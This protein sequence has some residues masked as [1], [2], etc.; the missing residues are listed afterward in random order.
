MPDNKGDT[1][2]AEGLPGPVAAWADS[3]PA[4]GADFDADA[5][6]F[7][8]FWRQ[9]EALL[10]RL[11]GKA[12]RGEE[13]QETARR[14]L[15]LGREAR[16]RF[17][18][19]H[20]GE[21]Y[22]R[23]TGGRS[24]F[25]RVEPLAYAAAE[26]VPG[27]TPTRAQVARDSDLLQKDKEGFE[28][29]QGI[30]LNRVLAD[31]EAGLHL[32]H[33]MLLPREE[34]LERLQH[35]VDHGRID[36]G[37]AAAVRRGGV[38]IAEM[39]NPRYLNAEDE[40]TSD[41]LEIALDLC[42]LDPE[43]AICVLRGG[44]VDHPKYAGRRIFG[45]GINLT[46]LYQGK[47][48]FLWYLTRDL[49]A[50][51]KIFRGLAKPETTPEEVLG[52]TIEKPWVAA[53][54]GF[55]IGGGC[56]LLLASDYVL[57]AKGAYMTLPARKEGIIPGA[58]NLRLWRFVG[59]RIARQAIQY[60]RRIDCDSEA[61]RLICDEIVEPEGM[62]EA[63]E[64]VVARFL[65][66]G[67]VSAA[68]NRRAFRIGQEPLDLFRRYMAFYAKAQATCHFSPQLIENLERFWQAASRRP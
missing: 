34:S 31:P 24:K 48:S 21:V 43:S 6:A 10:E 61:G 1:V 52:E 16:G 60:E 35:F 51:N 64:G 57:G 26:L 3:A 17:L 59:D 66:S 4:A 65:Q 2:A 63:V 39:R 11:P 68:A 9:G 50:V 42:L 44:T 41:S 7:A 22:A 28:I 33:A 5:E 15:D 58:A 40:T 55:A 47:I 45:S 25:V 54:D 20:A 67:L 27:L 23:L 32:C 8:G 18:E 62:D 12:R 29:D 49:G 13:E 38:S 53:V 19:K 37:T 30:F 56:Q 36:L 46:H 14:I